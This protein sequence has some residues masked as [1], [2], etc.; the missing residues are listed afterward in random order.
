MEYLIVFSLQI[1]D[2]QLIDS[3]GR[4]KPVKFQPISHVQN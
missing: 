4:L 2:C 3:T 1:K